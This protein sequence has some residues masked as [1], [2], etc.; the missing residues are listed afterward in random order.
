MLNLPRQVFGVLKKSSI[1][2]FT[3]IVATSTSV[4]AEDSIRVGIYQNPP[5]VFL[6]EEGKAA[7]FFPELLNEIAQQED[8][9]LQYVPCEWEQC[10]S[11]LETGKLDLMIDV[12]YSVSREQKFDFNQEVVF[13]ARSFFYTTATV[14]INDFATLDRKRVL[15]LDGSIQAEQ[16]QSRAESLGIEPIIIEVSNFKALFQ[17]LNTGKANIG[18]ANEFIGERPEKQYSNVKRSDLLLDSVPIHFA[19]TEGENQELLSRIDRALITLKDTPDSVYHQAL[20][21][22]LLGQSALDPRLILEIIII[23]FAITGIGITTAILISNRR[24]KQ[25]LIKRQETE[26]KLTKSE[27]QFKSL[28][29]NVP[30]ALLRYILY[31][32][33][34]EN[35]PYMSP[36]CEKMWEIKASEVEKNVE[37]LWELVH[38]DDVESIKE[39]IMLSAATLQTWFY[40]WRIITPSGKMKW[41][42]GRG[43]P[44]EGKDGAVCWDMIIFDV[45]EQKL[46]EASLK[47]TEQKLEQITD[48]IPGAVY[49]YKIDQEGQEFFLFMSKGIKNIF[50]FSPQEVMAD[51]NIMWDLLD[52]GARSRIKFFIEYSATTLSPWHS[53]F[54]VNLDG[55]KKWIKGEAIPQETEDGIIWNG[56]LVDISQQKWQEQILRTQQEILESLAKGEALEVIITELITLIEQQTQDLLGGVLLKVNNK[57]FNCGKSRLPQAYLEAI[58]GLEIEEGKGSCCTAMARGESVISEDITVDPLWEDYQ[59][60]TRKHNIRSCWSMPIFSSQGK[61]LGTFALYSDTPRKPTSYEIELIDIAT[62]LASLAIER[63]EQENALEKQA[64]EERLLNE[65]TQQVRHSL[66]LNTVLDSTVGEVRNYL[67]AD[68]VLVHSLQENSGKIIAESVTEGWTSLRGKQLNE[69]CLPNNSSSV[70]CF[71]VQKVNDVDQDD[72]HPCY[73]EMLRENE[74]RSNLAIPI[75]QDNEIWGFLIAQQ[76]AYTRQWKEEE[77]NFLR[78]LSQQVAIAIQQAQLYEQTQAELRKREQ[79]ATQLRHEAM[80]DKLTQLPNRSLL[81]DRLQHVFQVYHR[82]ET[83]QDFRFALLFLDLNRFKIINDT[84]GHDAGDQLL[85]TVAERLQGCL[86]EMDTISRLGGDEFVVIVEGINTE[87]D[88][89]EV[90]NRIH[91]ALTPSVNLNG[92]EVYIGTSIGIVMD[93]SRYSYP[94]EMLRDADIAMYEAKRN[95]LKYAVF[96]ASMEISLSETLQLEAELRKALE[97]DQFVWYYQPIFDL[98]NGAIKGF[99]ALLRWKHPKKGL[100]KPIEFISVAEEAGLI[101]EIELWTLEKACLQLKQWQTEFSSLQDASVH[102]NISSNQFHQEDFPKLVK[103]QLETVGLEAHCLKLEITET[104]LVEKQDLSQ[105]VLNELE[106]LGI[107]ICLDDFGVGYSS[108]S[109]LN[110][111]PIHEIKLDPSLIIDLEVGETRNKTQKLL[112]GISGLCRNLD[113]GAI[114]EGVETESQKLVLGVCG[115]EVAQ[116]FY[117]CKP[118]S[119]EEMTAYLRDRAAV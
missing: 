104:I 112:K 72:L 31:P 115:Y 41:L 79:L 16:L 78:K 21:N 15:V 62:K 8:W 96:D 87:E 85:I 60:I 35:I 1:A 116:G 117:F 110:Q 40:E 100:M 17:Q 12:A 81:M 54:E 5:K 34:S 94:E 61:V 46:I 89:V 22:W 23:A 14:A 50:G 108:L 3:L 19:T 83:Q 30:G 111:F 119:A 7:G 95:H 88:A 51:P 33:G 9:K 69:P 20:N 86:R 90:A 59:E 6:D 39:S 18:V 118:L 56:I 92:Q 82:R 36:V 73:A 58:N 113:I 10:L 55:G 66:D 2:L 91:E 13:R 84:L 102:I 76:C 43:N 49:Q 70:I 99:E 68:R 114:A 97:K 47:E 75:F 53:Q 52:E 4:K 74:V 103:K 45:T 105:K 26:A 80:H 29:N 101:N 28:I 32:D 93:D 38:P 42:Q 107:K 77:I 57:L 67:K 98:E 44:Q 64:I 24:L 37:I 71:Q 106:A 11:D 109:Y 25:E 48:A 63:K 27:E 65:I